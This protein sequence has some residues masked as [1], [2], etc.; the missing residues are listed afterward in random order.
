MMG[1][2]FRVPISK[3]VPVPPAP[4]FQDSVFLC[5][6][7]CPRTHSVGQAGLKLRDPPASRLTQALGSQAWARTLWL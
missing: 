6:P 1:V 7:G 2:G 5:S 3:T 4:V